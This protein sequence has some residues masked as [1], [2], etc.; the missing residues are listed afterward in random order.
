[1]KR[2]NKL[3]LQFNKKLNDIEG[4]LPIG[5]ERKWDI[6]LLFYH[7]ASLRQMRTDNTLIE[8]L[9]ARGYDLETLKFS[10]AKQGEVPT[11]HA[12]KI[13]MKR[14]YDF[15]EWLWEFKKTG[16]RLED[17][18]KQNNIIMLVRISKHDATK[19]IFKKLPHLWI[20][21]SIGDPVMDKEISMLISRF[22]DYLEEFGIDKDFNIEEYRELEDL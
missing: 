18:D 7:F 10:I 5:E 4:I 11:K 14:N 19:F 22:L 6:Y 13:S 21:K 1:M 8:E 20:V 16:Y 12:K 2:D 9:E 17:L 3:K 15:N